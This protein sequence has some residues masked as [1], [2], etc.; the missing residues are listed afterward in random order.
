MINEMYPHRR[1]DSDYSLVKGNY[2]IDLNTPSRRVNK[3]LETETDM[4]KTQN[5]LRPTI[6]YSKLPSAFEIVRFES[7]KLQPIVKIEEE[8]IDGDKKKN[9]FSLEPIKLR[10][11]IKV[12]PSNGISREI[13]TIETEFSKP[14]HNDNNSHSLKKNKFILK[15]IEIKDPRR[16]INQNKAEI[17]VSHEKSPEIK[18]SL[19]KHFSKTYEFNFK[20]LENIDL[21]NISML[22]PEITKLEE[23]LNLNPGYIIRNLS[24]LKNLQNKNNE[25]VKINMNIYNTNETKIKIEQMITLG[26]INSSKTCGNIKK[27]LHIPTLK[28]Y[29]VRVNKI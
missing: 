14:I 5:R 9:N 15:P 10:S 6:I 25:E 4:R 13:N 8:Q 11:I 1:N 3:I 27:M 20:L 21:N 24:Y 29:I 7:K 22:D 23:N 12:K 18:K 26:L 16:G 19:D 17:N 2:S 28:S